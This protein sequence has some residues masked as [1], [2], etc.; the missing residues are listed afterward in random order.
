MRIKSLNA[1][2]EL[3]VNDSLTCGLG[4]YNEFL[5]HMAS[6]WDVIMGNISNRNLLMMIEEHAH[7]KKLV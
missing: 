7:V 6:Y 4:S 2:L 5:E 1:I 3:P